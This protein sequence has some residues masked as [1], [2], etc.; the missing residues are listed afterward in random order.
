MILMPCE[1]THTCM[2]GPNGARRGKREG[3]VIY[4]MTTLIST[5]LDEADEAQAQ[6]G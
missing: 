3:T 6:G 2:R 1:H 4:E 5:S